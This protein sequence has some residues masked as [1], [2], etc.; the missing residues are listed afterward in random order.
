MLFSSSCLRL[1]QE[2][3]AVGEK[4]TVLEIDIDGMVI[5]VNNVAPREEI[6]YT[7]SDKPSMLNASR[8]TK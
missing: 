4:K 7:F 1:E 5:K 6:G 8:V 2:I 3:V